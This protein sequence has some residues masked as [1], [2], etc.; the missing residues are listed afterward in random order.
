MVRGQ[1]SSNLI[2]MESSPKPDLTVQGRDTKLYDSIHSG[3]RTNKIKSNVTSCVNQGKGIQNDCGPFFWRVIRDGLRE[4]GTPEQRP[5]EAREP[6]L[7][8]SGREAFQ[9]R[10]RKDAKALQG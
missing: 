4:E 10:G 8:T 3:N 9:A 2:T 6:T 7:I 1:H 5:E